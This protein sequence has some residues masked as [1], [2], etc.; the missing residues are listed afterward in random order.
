MGRRGCCYDNAAIESFW[1]TLKTECFHQQI[2]LNL[3]HAQAL[4]F[5]Y[6]ETFY[7]P[8]RLHSALGYLSPS[9]SKTASSP[10]QPMLFKPTTCPHFRSH[11]RAMRSR[12]CSQEV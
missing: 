3:Q 5:D 7:N 2:P 1:A 8:L 10:N 4:L 12:K 6:I 9:S 11:I